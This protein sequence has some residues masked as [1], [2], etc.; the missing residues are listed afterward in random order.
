MKKIFQKLPRLHYSRL[1]NESMKQFLHPK[2][3]LLIKYGNMA[4]LSAEKK[5]L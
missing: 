5:F 2:E 1:K 4:L 3:Y